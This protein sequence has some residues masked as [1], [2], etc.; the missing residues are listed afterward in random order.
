M[1]EF[2]THKVLHRSR[3]WLGGSAWHRLAQ[4]AF[5]QVA[6][7]KGY[8]SIDCSTYREAGFQPDIVIRR[9]ET[10]SDGPRKRK[11]WFSYAGE[12]VVTHAPVANYAKAAGLEDILVIRK[13]AMDN[14]DSIHELLEYCR[15]T[16]P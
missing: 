3:L 9:K 4:A 15:R 12:I 16:I 5:E 1:N 2:T 7:E 6:F 10:V 14:P 8:Q 13:D 11:E